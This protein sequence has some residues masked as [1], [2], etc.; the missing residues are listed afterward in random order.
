MVANQLPGLLEQ[1]RSGRVKVVTVLIGDN[2]F[3]NFLLQ[4]PG[5][6][7]DPQGLMVQLERTTVE[8]ESNV[9]LAVDAVLGANPDV[10]VVVGT[11]L[12]LTQTPLIRAAAAPY[13]AAGQQVLAATSR[14]IGDFNAEIRAFAAT[15]P[16]VAV[17]D[18]AAGF[19]QLAA[20]AA[21]TGGTIRV[22]GLAVRATSFGDRPTD[23]LLGD[24]YHPG[25][26]AQGFI[27]DAV[28]GAMDGAFGVGVAPL[29]AGQIAR[30]AVGAR[31]LP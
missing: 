8:A 9:G 20:Q 22:G 25:T 28:V 2:D 11:I 30:L 31:G 16:R 26:V 29:S 1:V 14:A 21:Q 4:A 13:G 18:L 12:D 7:H 5:Q 6:I 27:A 17:A 15:R 3:R 23:L 19:D 24:G 10:K